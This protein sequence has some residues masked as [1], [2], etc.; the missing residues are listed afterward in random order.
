MTRSQLAGLAGALALA[1]IAVFAGEYSTFDW[2]KVH[3]QLAAEQDSV[4]TLRVFL[5]SLARQTRALET[6]SATQER[7][8]RET[9]GMIRDGEII[10]RIVGEG[11]AKRP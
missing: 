1:G 2:L 9:Y 10:Y 3:R 6:D 4:R 8:A 5:D 11:T 7:V